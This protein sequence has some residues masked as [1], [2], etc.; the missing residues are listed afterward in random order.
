L[1]ILW[2]S[3]SIQNFMVSRWLVQVLHPPQKFE[4][5]PFWNGW[6]YGIKKHGIEV[7][8]NGVTSL[9]NFMKIYE[10]VQT[11]LGGT[12]RRTDRQ[13]HWWSHKPHFFLRKVGYKQ[14][15]PAICWQIWITIC[16]TIRAEFISYHEIVKEN[17]NFC[18]I[19]NNLVRICIDTIIT[20]QSVVNDIQGD[21]R[22]WCGLHQF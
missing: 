12:D 1:F 15:C 9:L 22:V 19:W 14:P 7:T 16:R 17:W 18:G 3:I 13:T 2:R 4:S 20:C 6:S 11:L 5:P 10:L 8:F 21:N